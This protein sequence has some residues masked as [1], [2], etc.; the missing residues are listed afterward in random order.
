MLR[1]L[2]RVSSINVRKVL[3]TLDEIGIPYVREDWGTGFRSTKEVEFQALNPKSL[4][5]VVIDGDLVLTESNT[6]IR[7]LANKHGRIDL[8]P[9]DLARRAHVE[10]WMDWQAS[11]LNTTWRYAVLALVRKNPAFAD[12]AMIEASFVEWHA[13]MLLLEAR[14]AQCPAYICGEAFTLADIVM[15][16]AINRWA[17]L[18]RALPALPA[19]AAYQ[20]R[21]L[22]RATA[23]RYIGEG[24][25]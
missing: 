13:K 15:G 16:L 5:P 18:P 7:Y 19:V 10:E 25:D 22:A 9:A 1:I 14:L 3:W 21:L 11:D 20:A 24:T 2:G 17:R 12:P 8:H 23:Q 4:V 6:I